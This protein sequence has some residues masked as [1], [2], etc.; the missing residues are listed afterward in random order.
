MAPTAMLMSPWPVISTTGRLL[1]R[2]LSRVSSCRP[3]M[4]G[5][6]MSLTTIPAKSSPMRSS[7]SSALPTPSLTMSSSASACWQPSNTWG[8]S[9]TIRTVRGEVFIS[10]RLAGKGC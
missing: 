6:R 9:S 5:K 2:A 8:S 7:A 10:A 4:P 3:S 1:S